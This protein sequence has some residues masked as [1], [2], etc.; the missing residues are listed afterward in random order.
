MCTDTQ[1]SLHPGSCSDGSAHI[2]GM[3]SLTAN[4]QSVRSFA[5]RTINRLMR[6]SAPTSPAASATP[7]SDIELP[8][9]GDTLRYRDEKGHEVLAYRRGHRSWVLDHTSHGGGEVLRFYST[10]QLLAEVNRGELL[11][12]RS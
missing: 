10:A 8:A 5:A 12:P 7:A 9:I 3:E 4:G 11:K 1:V 6:R 2:A